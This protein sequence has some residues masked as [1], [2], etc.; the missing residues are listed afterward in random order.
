ME[1]LG[2]SGVEDKLQDE[3]CQTIENIRN[4]GINVWM[5]TGDKVETAIC[6]AISSGIKSPQQS[7]FLI[8]EET[9][10]VKI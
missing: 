1:F 5:L 7:I 10:E 9:D 4:G 3:V 8:K 2:I 6:I